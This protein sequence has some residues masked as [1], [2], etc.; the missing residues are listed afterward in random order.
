MKCKAGE[1]TLKH[2]S[3][4]HHL[5]F[6]FLLCK[7]FCKFAH[8]QAAHPLVSRKFYK[9]HKSLVDDR[10]KIIKTFRVLVW[11]FHK[12]KLKWFKALKIQIRVIENIFS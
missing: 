7:T 2:K 1:E 9:S 5:T 4:G 10:K 12:T 6:P 11:F 8:L 3:Q